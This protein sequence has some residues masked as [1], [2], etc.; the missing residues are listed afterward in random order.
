MAI[1]L[2]GSPVVVVV[3]QNHDD[4]TPIKVVE[5]ASGQRSAAPA[6]IDSFSCFNNGFQDF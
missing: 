3:V 6:T 2:G 1:G 5:R 4:K